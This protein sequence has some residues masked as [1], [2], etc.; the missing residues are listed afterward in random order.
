MN[1][2]PKVAVIMSVYKSDNLDHFK[3]AVNS[4]L[5]QTY[6]AFSLFIWRDGEVPESIDNFLN[7]LEFESDVQVF[8]ESQ[9]RGLASALN[10]LID[11]VV[12]TDE[13]TYIARMDSD[14]ISYSTRLSKQVSFMQ[15]NVDVDVLGT[16]CREFGADFA[17]DKKCLP[18]S[19]DELVDFSVARC[20]F[21]HPSVML[22]KAIFERSELRYPTNTDFTEDMGLWFLLLEAGFRFANLPDIL[23]DYR[24]NDA[25]LSRRRGIGKSLSEVRIRLKY[26]LLLKRISFTNVAKV[27]SRLI[28]HVMPVSMVRVAY[29]NLR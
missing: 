19:H 22:R 23:L 7:E 3:E 20:P 11:K 24:L 6:D 29:K 18:Q 12:E 14:D 1:R 27:L 16:G 28:F 8:R 9:N 2:K 15:E 26:M 13:F 17:L 5:D 25:T 21:I 4:V 10:A